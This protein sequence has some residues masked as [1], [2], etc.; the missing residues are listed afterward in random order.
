M[1]PQTNKI[2]SDSTVEYKIRK[3][4]FSDRDYDTSEM[5]D[6][7]NFSVIKFVQ[8]S[9]EFS[10]KRTF[11][12]SID[13]EIKESSK[14]SV[15]NDNLDTKNLSTLSQNSFNAFWEKEDDD[16]WNSYLEE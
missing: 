12:F 13:S 8:N 2:V 10:S 6:T 16:Y 5:A 9:G 3:N 7:S 1:I 15:I 11:F 4:I 14:A